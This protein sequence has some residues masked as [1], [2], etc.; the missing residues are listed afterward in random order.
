MNAVVSGFSKYKSIILFSFYMEPFF[1]CLLYLIL[2]FS[3]VSTFLRFFLLLK[4]TLKFLLYL[5]WV[6]AILAKL[7]IFFTWSFKNRQ[8]IRKQLF[9]FWFPFDS[10]VFHSKERERMFKNFTW[11]FLTLLHHLYK[12][13]YFSIAFRWS[14]T[15]FFGWPTRWHSCSLGHTFS[16][17]FFMFWKVCDVTSAH[18]FLFLSPGLCILLLNI[19]IYKCKFML[20]HS[21]EV[22]FCM[23]ILILTF[24]NPLPTYS[25]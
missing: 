9:V 19:I 14:V 17:P 25:F 23:L 21:L 4:G 6:Y 5:I 18:L 20:C 16:F 15:F 2:Y 8:P 11:V 13:T 3:I 10:H 7:W 1:L 22:I 12:Q 24:R